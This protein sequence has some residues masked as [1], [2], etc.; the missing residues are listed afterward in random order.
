MARKA[1]GQSLIEFAV[2]TMV[3]I[4]VAL[5]LA[6]C[7]LIVCGLQVNETVCREAA[8]LASAGDPTYAVARAR[9]IVSSELIYNHSPFTVQLVEAETTV[10]KSQLEALRPYGGLVSGA[11]TVSTEV[12][13][14]PL[15]LSWFLG[16]GAK[17]LHFQTKQEF[18]CTYVMPNASEHV[19][20]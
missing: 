12:A 19:S 20:I 1:K 4:P 17:L 2:S 3:F 9:Q 6:D 7:F 16:G 14:K 8:R 15:I 11:V 13:V 10:N 18:P 5:L